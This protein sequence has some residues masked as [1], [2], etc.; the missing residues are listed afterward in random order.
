MHIFWHVDEQG[1]ECPQGSAVSQRAHGE[2]V[3]SEQGRKQS[4]QITSF[5]PGLSPTDGVKLLL[6]EKGIPREENIMSYGQ[7][8]K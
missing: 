8:E 7:G 2:L 1:W 3:P 6:K 4:P 5:P